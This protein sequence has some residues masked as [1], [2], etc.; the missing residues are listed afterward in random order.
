MVLE[1]TDMSWWK[2]KLMFTGTLQDCK[3]YPRAGQQYFVNRRNFNWLH[4]CVF[5]VH[6]IIILGKGDCGFWLS[7]LVMY[8]SDAPQKIV[9]KSLYRTDLPYSI[10]DGGK[11]ARTAAAAATLLELCI[12]DIKQSS[13]Y[14][15][16]W[17]TYLVAC[18]Q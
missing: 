15:N 12:S 1:Q 16:G 9:T 2:Y 17:S 5:R 14:S 13:I 6:Y 3:F 10:L 4:G 8:S 18:P 11:V 7:S